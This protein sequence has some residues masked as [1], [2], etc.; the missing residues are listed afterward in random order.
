MSGTFGATR[1]HPW[2]RRTRAHAASSELAL[3]VAVPLAVV[4]TATI[5]FTIVALVNR[6]S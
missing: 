6:W 5:V 1:R 3:V 2:L 4:L